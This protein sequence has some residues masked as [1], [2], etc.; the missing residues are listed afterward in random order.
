MDA[1]SQITADWLHTM[2]AQ[3]YFWKGLKQSKY[4]WVLTVCL[5]VLCTCFTEDKLIAFF[6]LHIQHGDDHIYVFH[7]FCILLIYQQ[8]HTELPP[9]GL[10]TRLCE[11]FT[12]CFL[13]TV[14]LKWYHIVLVCYS[15]QKSPPFV[16]IWQNKSDINLIIYSKSYVFE[17]LI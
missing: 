3:T 7:T 5:Q 17:Q 9:L 1:D 15:M 14:Q 2:F 6:Y 8:T 13:I 4:L 12:E 16:I 11:A 10:N